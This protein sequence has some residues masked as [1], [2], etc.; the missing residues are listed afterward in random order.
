MW[1]ARVDDLQ[2][3]MGAQAVQQTPV[4]VRRIAGGS[5][6]LTTNA[7][8]TALP[9]RELREL[10]QFDGPPA[11]YIVAMRSQMQ[12]PPTVGFTM[13][14]ACFLVR[15]QIGGVTFE[16]EVDGESDQFLQ[17]FAEHIEVYAKW[18]NINQPV[19]VL[20][21]ANFPRAHY[22]GAAILPAFGANPIAKRSIWLRPSAGAGST[23]GIVP[24]AAHR[25]MVRAAQTSGYFAG[26]TFQFLSGAAGGGG[27]IIDEWTSAQILAAHNIG[28]QFPVHSLADS[29]NID[30]GPG[31]AG[32]PGTVEFVLQP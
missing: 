11:I 30:W 8:S 13:P 27:F 24:Y 2:E 14:C 18:D 15:W 32:G 4:G 19:M 31:P 7:D 3:L 23:A 29:F 6:I 28:S 25:F 22:M 16:V 1:P 9:D 21:P 26:G 10:T 12:R 5:T 20:L 17:V